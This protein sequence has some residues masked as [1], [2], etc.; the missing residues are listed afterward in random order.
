MRRVGA[1]T[2]NLHVSWWVCVIVGVH[3]HPGVGVPASILAGNE[4][5]CPTSQFPAQSP[6]SGYA[7]LSLGLASLHH[8]QH[9]AACVEFDGAGGWLPA[10]RSVRVCVPSLLLIMLRLSIVSQRSPWAESMLING[11]TA[12]V[13]CLLWYVHTATLWSPPAAVRPHMSTFGRLLRPVLC[14]DFGRT[15]CTLKI[16]SASLCWHR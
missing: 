7:C 3:K 9:H 11:C 12:A 1:I 10:L 8:T 2:S 14:S 6:A 4:P 16:P 13:T 5:R 15:Q